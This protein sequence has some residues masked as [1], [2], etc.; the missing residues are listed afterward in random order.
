MLMRRGLGR[1]ILAATI[2]G[3]SLSALPAAAS[4]LAGTAVRASVA[5]ASAPGSLDSAFGSGGASLVPFGSWIA[6]AAVAVQPDGKIVTAG[7]AEL[8]G[9]MYIVST[10]MTSGGQLDPTYGHRGL[11]AV[12]I[13]GGAGVDSGDALALQPDGKI[14]IAATGHNGTW[15]QLAFAAVR[16]NP[17]GSQDAT[18]GHHGVALAAIGAS[19]MANGVAIQHDGKIVLAGTANTGHNV[20]AAARFNANGTL[21]PSFGDQGTTT[22]SPTGGAWGLVIQGDGKLV[23]AGQGD[24]SNPSVQNAQQ[25]MAA[26]LN[27][28][29]TL[30]PT[31]GSGGID[32]IPVG[33]S[34]LGYGVAKQADG[35][36]VLSGIAWT[37]T[38]VN[39]VVRLNSDGSLDSSYGQGGIGTIIDGYGA[40]GIV[41]DGAGRAVLPTT[42]AGAVRFNPNGTPDLAFG[43]NGIALAQ[44]GTG[45][46]ANGAAIQPGDGKIV[47]GGAATVNGQTVL[48]VIRLN[49]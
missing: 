22:L 34:A 49:P 2:G 35:K 21:D 18:F 31:F 10:R 39:A 25:F 30:D 40:N 24:Y 11:V 47:L 1:A 15:G 3:L 12:D 8:N 42:G 46:A 48:S 29:G 28:D 45:G 36:L 20:F 6:A 44:I 23:L 9:T 38:T 5:G 14:L 33:A 43:N 26:R 13:Y 32:A 7:Q 4:A 19:A 17:N 37:S 27:T 16:L 41:L